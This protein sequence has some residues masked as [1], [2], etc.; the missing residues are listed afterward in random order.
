M[1]EKETL[2]ERYNEGKVSENDLNF[3]RKMPF[4]KHKGKPIY[5]LLVKHWRYMDW[6]THNT[7]FQLNETEKWWKSKIDYTIEA[8]RA[9]NI[10]SGLCRLMPLAGELPITNP[11]LIV[12]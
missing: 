9:D 10:I 4:G 2:I 3:G 7:D 11:H 12:E 8:I 6:I 5:H 1:S